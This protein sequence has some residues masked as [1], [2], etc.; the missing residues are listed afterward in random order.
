MCR[1][2]EDST[3]SGATATQSFEIVGNDIRTKILQALGDARGL[4]EGPPVLTFSELRDIV[5][6]DIPSSQFNYHLQQLVGRFIT[7]TGDG[8]QMRPAGMLLYRTIRAGTITEELSIEPFGIGVDCYRCGDPIE[9]DPSFGEIWIQCPTCDEFYDMVMAPPGGIG[10]SDTAELLRRLDQYNRHRHIGFMRGICPICMNAVEQD[11]VTLN[12]EPYDRSQCRNW[13]IHWSCHHCGNRRFASLGMALIDSPEV[14]SL[15]D[16]A[17]IA[18]TDRTVWE[19]EWAMTDRPVKVIEEDPFQF[20]IN[21]NIDDI[22]ANL[23]IDHEL[24]VSS[25]SIA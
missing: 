14:I 19:F 3:T 1:G 6:V 13:H 18:P 10:S 15:F 7:H 24:N 20:S 17:T 2:D 16:E 4:R 25:S 5:P 12:E 11:I 22:E 21:L 23:L 8:Y 9:A